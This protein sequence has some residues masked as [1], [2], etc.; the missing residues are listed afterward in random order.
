MA[1]GSWGFLMCERQLCCGENVDEA[2]EVEGGVT[3]IPIERSSMECQTDAWV[4]SPARLPRVHVPEW[5]PERGGVRPETE[6]PALDNDRPS[7]QRRA[8]WRRR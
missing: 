8:I 3:V 6:R 5:T 7:D 4:W 2:C 1:S